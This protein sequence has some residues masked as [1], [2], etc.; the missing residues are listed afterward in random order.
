MKRN[1]RSK[2]E[3]CFGMSF[4]LLFLGVVFEIAGIATPKSSPSAHQAMLVGGVL[5]LVAV[6]LFFNAIRLARKGK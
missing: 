5:L 4:W 2:S 3:I 6:I 1:G